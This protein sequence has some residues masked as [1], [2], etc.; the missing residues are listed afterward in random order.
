[1]IDVSKFFIALEKTEQGLSEVDGDMIERLD[2]FGG[3]GKN[4]RVNVYKLLGISGVYRL[5]QKGL[6]FGIERPLCTVINEN[7]AQYRNKEGWLDVGSGPDSWLW[8][9]GMDPLGFDI[10]FN[11]I[12]SYADKPGMGVVGSAT[13]LPFRSGSIT[14]VFSLGVLHHLS[15]GQA[16][17]AVGEMIRACRP[18]G[19]VLIVDGVLPESALRHPLAWIIRKLDRGRFMRRQREISALLPGTGNWTLNR[20]TYSPLGYEG[21][22]CKYEKPL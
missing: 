7:L 9:L 5:V 1:M 3:P 20:F 18:G 13:D 17:Q 2:R 22:A 10:E 11:Y 15:T 4:M 21:V 16:R 8:K 19:M 12:K 14:G 6:A